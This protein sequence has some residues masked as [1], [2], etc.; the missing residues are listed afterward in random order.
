MAGAAGLLKSGGN[1]GGAITGTGGMI[2]AGD[3]GGV[4]ALDAASFCPPAVFVE[5][6][7]GFTEM[8][9]VYAL[10]SL[11]T[12]GWLATGS[13]TGLAKERVA[14]SEGRAADLP[15]AGDWN[16]GFDIA[17]VLRMGGSTLDTGGSGTNGSIDG[18]KAVVESTAAGGSPVDAGG[19][20]VVLDVRNGISGLN[21]PV[22]PEP[23]G[24]FPAIPDMERGSSGCDFTAPNTA[25]KSPTVFR[26]GSTGGADMAGISDGLSPR[27]GP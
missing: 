20:T 3:G 8:I 22:K 25:V 15:P 2:N 6:L 16:T 21:H 13:M 19:G 7:R 11:G 24:S 14:P 18:G 27:N 1:G 10:G 12:S 9:C 4:V 26:G 23:A 17:G 5:A